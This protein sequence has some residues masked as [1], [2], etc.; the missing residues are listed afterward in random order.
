MSLWDVVAK[1]DGKEFVKRQIYNMAGTSANWDTPT[2]P[3]NVVAS[4]ADP[5]YYDR[6]GI[7]YPAKAVPMGPSVDQGTAEHLRLLRLKP[8]RKRWVGVYY[9]QSGIVAYEV[10]EA[11]KG[12]DLDETLDAMLIFGP[13]CR[14]KGVARGNEYA[15]W[16]MPHPNSRGIADRHFPADEKRVYDFVRRG[17]MYAE[18]DDSDAGEDMTMVFNVVQDP[19]ALVAGT[20][21]ALEQ[22]TEI[23]TSPLKEIPSAAKAI[24]NGLTFLT[25]KNPQGQVVP[26]YPH[27][28]Y[29]PQP[30]IRLVN[31]I[32]EKWAA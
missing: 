32:G 4:A 30:A 3:T 26:T 27:I 2:D 24:W 13:P 12:S 21:S 17:D 22:V 6:Q 5:R 8:P 19:K 11:I 10:Y 25:A 7:W 1:L 14:A 31:E 29:D 16:E 28:S 15:G 23:F 20:D 9:S 18:V